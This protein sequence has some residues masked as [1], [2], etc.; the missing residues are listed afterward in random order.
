MEETKKTRTKILIV[1]DDIGVRN[2]Y[3]E[4]FEEKGFEVIEAI[5]GVDG[6]DKATKKTPDVIFTGIIMPRMDGFGLVEALKKNVAT[7]S[8]PII[9]SSHLGREQDRQR[10]KSLGVKDFIVLGYYTPREVVEKFKLLFSAREYEL[11]II[12]NELGA[13]KLA[14][15][16]K[17]KEGL[18]CEKCNGEL[19]LSLRVADEKEKTFSAKFVCLQCGKAN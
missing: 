3:A 13:K 5:D 10:A 7:S 11:K 15:D 14:S 2:L 17:I 4:V 12:S 16:L 18:R 9:M 19:I 8:I 6:L 1:D